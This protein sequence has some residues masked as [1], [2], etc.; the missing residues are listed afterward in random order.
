MSISLVIVVLLPLILRE[1]D[2]EGKD[3]DGNGCSEDDSRGGPAVG[4]P[5]GTGGTSIVPPAI[6]TL[7][8]GEFKEL[9]SETQ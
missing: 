8:L 7:N 6:Q 1:V 5:G 3:D 9:I 4:L 2:L